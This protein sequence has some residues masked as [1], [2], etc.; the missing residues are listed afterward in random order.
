[1]GNNRLNNRSKELIKAAA[2]DA[3]LPLLCTVSWFSLMQHAKDCDI[4]PVPSA[5]TFRT[6]GRGAKSHL[7]P[8]LSDIMFAGENG[9]LPKYNL[10]G[11]QSPTLELAGT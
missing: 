1:M 8:G 7:S 10:S 6:G 11:G 2:Y 4:S 3:V 5:E 9:A